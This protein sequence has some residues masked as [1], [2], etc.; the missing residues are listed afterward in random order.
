M[1]ANVW[2]LLSVF[3]WSKFNNNHNENWSWVGI[4]YK[5]LETPI[6]PPTTTKQTHNCM[7]EFGIELY[8]EKQGVS[9]YEYNMTTFSSLV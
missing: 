2:V 4:M 1:N 5:C 7:K 8:L 6:N 9:M 3:F